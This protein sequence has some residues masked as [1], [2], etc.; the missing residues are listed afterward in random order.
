MIIHL[1]EFIL[2]YHTYF[3]DIND[4]NFCIFEKMKNMKIEIRDTIY[5]KL[6]KFK[7]L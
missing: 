4:Y 3:F 2:T 5:I 1:Y 7:C 6:I